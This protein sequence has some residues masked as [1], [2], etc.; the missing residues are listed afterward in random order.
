MI[1]SR[2]IGEVG[3]FL[4]NTPSHRLV[5]CFDT[6]TLASIGWN[7]H[8]TTI[9]IVPLVVAVSIRLDDERRSESVSFDM[10]PMTPFHF[11]ASNISYED[12]FM[13]RTVPDLSAV[14]RVVAFVRLPCRYCVDDSIG[15]MP[16][17]GTTRQIPKPETHISKIG[18]DK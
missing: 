7:V 18:Q 9:V 4:R 15:I 1:R 13:L 12:A 14:S 17:T 2:L 8:S 11:L 10:R 3:L 16:S 5:V 6:A